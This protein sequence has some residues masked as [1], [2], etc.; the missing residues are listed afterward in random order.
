MT[1]AVLSALPTFNLCTFKMHKTVIH[2]ID[3]YRSIGYG[4]VMTLMLQC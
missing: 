1:N 2:Q 4:E 3:K